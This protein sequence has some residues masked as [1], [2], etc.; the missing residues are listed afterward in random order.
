MITWPDK[1]SILE[2][3]LTLKNSGPQKQAEQ[4]LECVGTD[5]KIERFLKDKIHQKKINTSFCS[6][7]LLQEVLS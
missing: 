1:I 3:E 7:I 6:S 2:P 5:M 4:E